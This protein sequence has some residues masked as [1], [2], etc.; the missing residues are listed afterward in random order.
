MSD[1]VSNRDIAAQ[2]AADTS[3][4]AS[5]GF[6]RIAAS[7]LPWLACGLLALAI[8]AVYGRSLEAPFVF[9]DG[10]SVLTNPSIKELFPL[11]GPSAGTTPLRP[12]PQLS[13]SGRPLVNLMLAVNYRFGGL[14]P[15]GYHLLNVVI[16]SLAAMLLFAILRRSLRLEYF[17]GRFDRVADPLAWLV[18]L[19]WALHPLQTEAVEYITQRTELMMGLFYLA[20][21]YA[22]MRYFTVA[23]GG[24]KATWCVLASL[25]CLLGMACKEVMVTAPVMVLCYERTFIAGSFRKSLQNSWR[26][27]LGLA[28]GWLL[29]L[30]LNYG[31]PRSHTTGFGASTTFYSWWLTQAKVLEIYL[32]LTFWPWPLVIHYQMPL[33]T[34]PLAVWPS[35]LVVAILIVNTV[36]RFAQRRATGYLGVWFFVILS[37]T[38]IVPILTEVAAERRM[39]LPLAAIVALVIVGGFALLQSVLSRESAAPEKLPVSGPLAITSAC[40]L[41]VA[42]VFAL[43]SSHRLTAYAT[44]VALWQDAVIHQPDNFMVLSNL[45]SSLMLAGQEPEA[46]KYFDQ[47]L[48]MN[49]AHIQLKWGHAL[50]RIG[51]PDQAVAHLEELVR[52]APN[53]AEHQKY[54]GIA[55]AESGRPQEALRYLRRALELDPGADDVQQYLSQVIVDA[56]KA[57]DAIERLRNAVQAQP[58]KAQ[59]H[60]DLGSALLSSGNTDE[61]IAE[62]EQA[63]RLEPGFTAAKRQLEKAKKASK[64]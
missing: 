26:L 64:P 14:N 28:C 59:L 55:L 37:P 2:G 54:L 10:P 6:N 5:R 51:Q 13:T 34:A 43:V 61:A 11:F 56:Q 29:L 42:G 60:Y 49:P 17:Q 45:A 53:S 19:V 48:P 7:A 20:T 4:P 52:L 57:A 44:N 41:I 30:A 9:D 25:A 21:M 1:E 12:P 35:L 8:F 46:A 38:L 24:R 50:I 33:V 15:F 36:I 39:Y 63:L 32:K 62:L 3:Q 58:D 16:H 27:Y 40:A 31:G 18:A 47:A 23:S 22:S